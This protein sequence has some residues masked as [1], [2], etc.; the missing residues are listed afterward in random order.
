MKLRN[1]PEDFSLKV[2]TSGSITLILIPFGGDEDIVYA[3]TATEKD[4]LTNTASDLDIILLAWNGKY[5]TD[6]FDYGLEDHEKHYQ[7]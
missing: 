3:N 2:R 7:S 4:N 6:I 1:L 5:K